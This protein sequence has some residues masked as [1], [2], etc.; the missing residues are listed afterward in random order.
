VSMRLG[1]NGYQRNGAVH[2]TAYFGTIQI[3]SPPQS[4]SMVFDTGSGNLLVPAAD[5]H[6]QACHSHA[7]FSHQDSQTAEDTSCD[8]TPTKPGTSPQRD[9]VTITFGTGEIWGRCVQ[10]LICLG[11]ICDRGSFI[12]ATYESSV[13]FSA[14][15]FDGVLGLALD[16]MSQGSDFNMMERLTKTQALR[17]PLFSV[18]LSDD[19]KEHSEVNFGEVKHHH[20]ATELFWVDVAR[21]SGYWEVAIDGIAVDDQPLGICAG[22]FVAVDTGTSE[23]AGP[24]EVVQQLA[25]RLDVQ[26]DCSNYDSLPKLGF[27]T[28][29]R[30]LNLEP[31]DYI[32][33]AEGHCEISLMPL[34]V[35]PPQG[36]L[37]VFG[38][39]FLQRFYTVYNKAERKI[40]FAVARHQGQSPRQA[41]ALPVSNASVSEQAKPTSSGFLSM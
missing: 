24:S 25:Q 20:M 33:R 12:T 39:P 15:A 38:I 13:P 27:Q 29:G 23:L 2:K 34:D 14:F 40:G 4:F 8:G 1:S 7:R 3:G 30:I 28:A 31:R 6:S 32:D 21:A 5:C 16:G 37:F 10:D 36:P 11:D 19:D 9:E 22:C 18:F 41:A 17:Q 26:S 35:P